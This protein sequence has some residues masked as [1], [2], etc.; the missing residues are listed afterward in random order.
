MKKQ[1]LRILFL[2]GFCIVS[3]CLLQ[4]MAGR[5]HKK[6]WEKTL[7]FT[8]E[9]GNT[10]AEM[11]LNQLYDTF[12]N[13]I[14]INA[15]ILL[16]KLKKVS[17]SEE[18]SQ[19]FTWGNYGHAIFF[20]WAFNDAP[21][22]HKPL[23]EQL[24]KCKMSNSGYKTCLR[25]V[26]EEWNQRKSKC[27]KEVERCL[28]VDRETAAAIAT[29]L[30]DIHILADY[31]GNT[32]TRPLALIKDLKQDLMTHGLQ[33]LARGN[34]QHEADIKLV[35]DVDSSRHNKIIAEQLL[36]NLSFFLPQCLSD[37]CSESL[38]E[39]GIRIQVKQVPARDAA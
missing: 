22:N 12:S 30:H 38:L 24:K 9:E 2:T 39:R 37:R 10:G 28:G 8:S 36:E 3:L 23:K 4:G 13:A 31:V 35:M 6:E 20:H 21:K 18:G 26:D 14:D 16:N 15:H 32:R 29:L 19:E 34:P 1:N 7:G 27:L 17:K 5:A 25:L 11:S 33:V